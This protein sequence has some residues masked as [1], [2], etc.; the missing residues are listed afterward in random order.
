[1]SLRFL[2][3]WL[4]CGVVLGSGLV[5]LGQTFSGLESNAA[6][7]SSIQ[8]RGDKISLKSICQVQGSSFDSPYL[9]QTVKLHGVVYADFDQ[10]RYGFYMQ[11][12][13]CDHNVN[14]SDGIFVYLGGN[15]QTVDA[16]DL[17]EVSGVVQEYY[18]KTEISTSPLSVTVL[19]TGNTLPAPVEL[20][21]PFDD[22]QAAYY[23]ET[24]ES[25]Y[26]SLSQARV[27]GPTNSNGE[28][29]VVPADLGVTRVFYDDPMGT[30]E[31]IC[32]DDRG[33]FKIEPQVAVGDQV[34]GLIGALDY[35]MGVYRLQLLAQPVVTATLLI[36]GR[37]ISQ[38]ALSVPVV[39][40]ATFNLANMFDALDDPVTED[41]V[42]TGA[43]FN[44]RLAKRALVIADILSEP[45]ILAVQEVE[46]SEVMQAL[47]DRDEI[48]AS[49][50][51][52]I[53]DTP[54]LRGLDVALLARADRVVVLGYLQHQ[55]CTQLVDGFGPDGNGDHNEPENTITCDSD[56]D[57]IED[58]NRL[59]SR[60]PLVVHLQL[61]PHTSQA[62]N[63]V[64][65]DWLDT[66]IIV[67]HW[68]SKIEDTY[69]V[70]YT[71]PRRIQQA[72]FVAGLVD[73]LV[74]TYPQAS[75]VVMGDLN[76]H[77]DSQPLTELVNAGLMDLSLQVE[78]P[79]RYSY[80]YQGISQVL[81]Y[82]LVRTAPSLY[83]L[84][85]QYKPINSDY[86]EEF[87]GDSDSIHRSSDHDPML[88]TFAYFR[89][90]EYIPLILR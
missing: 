16:G 10:K 76:D 41:Q 8:G 13:G 62:P 30:G 52:V 51:Y 73:E 32:I 69:S 14:T 9:S 6:Q 72:Q 15:T 60:P 75:V 2:K 78:K 39:T 79:Q 25:M 22:G 55:G 89:F 61:S 1:V 37:S 68:K 64:M 56:G 35:A 90:F 71:L 38:E 83:P 81:D 26:V 45:D 46:N 28:A 57:G 85:I 77:S 67:N 23:L 27:V 49:Y 34:A 4:L 66:F 48:S 58:G 50:T 5:L 82:A 44:R 80:N 20:T 65:G 29:W 36:D 7:L 88:V 84:T 18:G 11:D 40:M 59:F 24:H 19:S 47:I 21:P 70:Q 33:L 54:D 63:S 86:P 3:R 74:N 42:L 53:S 12:D 43:E 17:V 87:S 31:V